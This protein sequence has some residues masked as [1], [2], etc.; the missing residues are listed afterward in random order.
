M[1]SLL[2][3]E[4]EPMLQSLASFGGPVL[5]GLNKVDR[6]PEKSDLLPLLESF[7]QDGRF[8]E[9]VPFSAK[10]GS[11]VDGLLQERQRVLR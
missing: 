2:Q 6:I 5:L 9:L 3:S 4:A 10:T 7:D 8:D 1:A 11:G